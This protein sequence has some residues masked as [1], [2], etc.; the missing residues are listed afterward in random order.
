MS[1]GGEWGA[2]ASLLSLDPQISYGKESEE[3][4]LDRFQRSFLGEDTACGAIARPGDYVQ[5]FVHADP[6]LPKPRARYPSSAFGVGEFSEEGYTT[7]TVD[8]S[9]RPAVQLVVNHFGAFTAEGMYLEMWHRSGRGP[10]SEEKRM[11][12]V[13][14]PG[15][16]MY[17]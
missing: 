1:G 14:V 13:N 8:A 12:K 6:D 7:A 2:K 9:T 3:D 15:T 11:T 5:F 4:E 17:P 10:F 16:I